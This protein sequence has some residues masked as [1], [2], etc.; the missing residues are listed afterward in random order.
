MTTRYLPEWGN[1]E[2]LRS[3]DRTE[4]TFETEPARSEI[5]IEQ[6]LTHTSGLEYSLV[7]QT[8]QDLADWTE[9]TDPAREQLAEQEQGDT[10]LAARTQ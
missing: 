1:R 6:L 9:R 5:T 10:E 7:N 8:V 4:G 2:V 3:I